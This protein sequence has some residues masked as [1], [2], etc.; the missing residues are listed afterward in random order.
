MRI[1]GQ[2]PVRLSG[3]PSYHRLRPETF[4]WSYTCL[5]VVQLTFDFEVQLLR[6][7]YQKN[8]KTMAIVLVQESY[9]LTELF[10]IYRDFPMCKVNAN[11]L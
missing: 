8:A 3:G 2:G 11:G 6:S 10:K 9:K 5:M 1:C 4:Q 7:I